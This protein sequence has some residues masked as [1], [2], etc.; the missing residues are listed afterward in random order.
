MEDARSAIEYE[1]QE[2]TGALVYD[3]D[4]KTAGR[5]H[6]AA[7]EYFGPPSLALDQ[8][9][10][11]L[12]HGMRELPIM[13]DDEAAPYLPELLRIPKTNAY[14]FE[15]DMFHTL[16]CLNAVRVEVS[17]SL[18]NTTSASHHHS[19]RVK[20]PDGWD[21]LHMEHCLDRLRQSIMCHGDLTP[22]PLYYWQGFDIALGRTGKRT[23]RKWEP[24][25]KWMDE[26]AK[27][28][29]ALESF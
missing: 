14:H 8:K 29:K 6:D 27:R 15:P 10:R 21:V 5:R 22:S 24:I 16:H 20:L 7:V 19:T 25:R 18:Y 17:K 9:W 2:Y 1:E 4:T 26:R 12:L 11:Q 28:G 3:P 23:C 13:T